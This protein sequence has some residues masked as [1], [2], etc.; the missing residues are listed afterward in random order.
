MPPKLLIHISWDVIKAFLNIL[1][2]TI[3]IWMLSN[4]R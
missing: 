3:D 1:L 2:E 4:R